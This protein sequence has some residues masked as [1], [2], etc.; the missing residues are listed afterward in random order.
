M[1]TISEPWSKQCDIPHIRS[2]Y[3][4]YI[5]PPAALQQNNINIAQGGTD[6]SHFR[7]RD[8]IMNQSQ[9]LEFGARAVGLRLFLSIQSIIHRLDSG[10]RITATTDI[11]PPVARQPTGCGLCRFFI[12]D[13]K[14]ST[15]SAS[16]PSQDGQQK[17]SIPYTLVKNILI[18]PFEKWRKTDTIKIISN[19]KIRKRVF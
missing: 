2:L 15:T 16:L 3:R 12:M 8:E 13:G 14:K 5:P 9:F 7:I 6:L 18:N 10:S 1:E 19:G 11:L 17:M 4:H